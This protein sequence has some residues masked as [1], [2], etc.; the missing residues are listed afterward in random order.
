MSSQFHPRRH[1]I[2]ITLLAVVLAAI[3]LV[4]LAMISPPAADAQSVRGTLERGVVVPGDELPD[5][6]IPSLDPANGRR[7]YGSKGCVICHSMNGIGGT[8]GINGRSLDARRQPV[9]M[10]PFEF[11][12]KMWTSSEVMIVEQLNLG[13]QILLNGDEFADLFAFINSRDEQRQF[14]EDDVPEEFL[15][16]F[17]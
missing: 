2:V 12:A 11:A 17:E 13:G 10:D 7:L 9:Q 1:T 15:E 4:L 5:L 16:F 6:V 8:D 3:V 14:T